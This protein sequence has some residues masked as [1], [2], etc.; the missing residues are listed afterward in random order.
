MFVALIGAA[1]CL[2]SL[3]QTVANRPADGSASKKIT[4][5]TKATSATN[6][7][8]AKQSPVASPT[9]AQ[10]TPSTKKTKGK[11]VQEQAQLPPPPPTPAQSPP[12]PARVTMQNG[13]LTIDANNATL[14][15]VLTGVRRETKAAIDLPA[16]ASGERVVANLGPG[17]PQNVLT[18]LLNGSRFDYI[19]LGSQDQPDAV[20]RVILRAKSGPEPTP[21]TLATAQRPN[22]GPTSV[23]APPPDEGDDQ[24]A[25]AEEIQDENNQPQQQQQQ[26]IDGEQQQ[27]QQQQGQQQQGQQQQGEPGQQQP[28]QQQPGVKTP[29]QLLE[30][31]RQMQQQQQQQQQEQQQ[32]QGQ[33]QPY[34]Q[35]Q[36][37][38]PQQ[39]SPD[40]Q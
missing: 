28:Q 12:N 33:P 8:A 31:L 21:G 24:G 23:Q 38:Q 40:E 20:Q 26:E 2:P 39:P 19:I 29:E 6:P 17:T 18:A 5:T 27:G 15:D 30:E 11:K 9:V 14:A 36:Q 32:Q 37:Q 10:K 4:T 35:Q 7:T 3:A 22:S 34:Q 16:G 13:L 1:V 25:P